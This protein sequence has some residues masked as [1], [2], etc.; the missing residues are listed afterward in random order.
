MDY[1]A[2]FADPKWISFIEGKKDIGGIF[3]NQHVKEYV[4][5]PSNET[6]EINR[7]ERIPHF[8]WKKPEE[9][10]GPKDGFLEPYLRHIYN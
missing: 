1:N 5:Y 10:E 3:M 6:T 8:S 7:L 4:G 2:P 9:P